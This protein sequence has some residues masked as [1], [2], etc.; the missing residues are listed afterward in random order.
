MFY[1]INAD[2]MFYNI[3]VDAMFYNINADAMFS[4][5]ELHTHVPIMFERGHQWWQEKYSPSTLCNIFIM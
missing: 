1:N 4:T 2:A 5:C 3:N